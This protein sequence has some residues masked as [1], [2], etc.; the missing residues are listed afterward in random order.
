[1]PEAF[2]PLTSLLP[3]FL[4]QPHSLALP[5]LM[6]P[7]YACH[8]ICARLVICAANAERKLSWGQLILYEYVDKSDSKRAA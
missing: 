2:I 4:P 8:A 3:R 1:V 6:T 7:H 5:T